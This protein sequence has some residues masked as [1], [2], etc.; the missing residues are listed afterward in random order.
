M[1]GV[2]ARGKQTGL[3]G[4]WFLCANAALIRVRVDLEHFGEW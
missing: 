3:E 2:Y 4:D 1:V